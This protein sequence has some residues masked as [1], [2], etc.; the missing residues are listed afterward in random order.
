MEPRLD[1]CKARAL[2]AV[3]SLWPLYDPFFPALGETGGCCATGRGAQH[4]R[5]S[6]LRVVSTLGIPWAITTHHTLTSE[7]WCHTQAHSG[8]LPSTT[9]SRAVW[10]GSWGVAI[11]RQT[12]CVACSPQVAQPTGNP[13]L[14]LPLF[15]LK[16]ADSKRLKAFLGISALPAAPRLLL[17][18]LEPQNP[19]QN[20]MLGSQLCP[21]GRQARGRNARHRGAGS[22]G[23]CEGSSS[24]PATTGM[25]PPLVAG[26]WHHSDLQE[27]DLSL[28]GSCLVLGWELAHSC[29]HPPPLPSFKAFAGKPLSKAPGES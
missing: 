22:A 27:P 11:T 29:G 10:P 8:S 18:S 6:T 15:S 14:S 24:L 25:L 28:T 9:E 21:W 20:Y 19:H 23:A 13:R 4:S 5:G 17:A 1:T 16:T 26:I 12:I 3:P 2:P 7:G